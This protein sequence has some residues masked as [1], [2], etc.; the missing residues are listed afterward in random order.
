MA[1]LE[2]YHSRKKKSKYTEHK[3]EMNPAYCRNN[4]NTDMVEVYGM[5]GRM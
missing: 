3:L 2:G 4:K 1:K 5:S